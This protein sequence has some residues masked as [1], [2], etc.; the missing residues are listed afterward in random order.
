MNHSTKIPKNITILK[1]LAILKI[2]FLIQA[3]HV[4]EIAK[5]LLLSSRISK[6]LLLFV[7]VVQFHTFK[8]SIAKEKLGINNM[9]NVINNFN[10][11]FII[12]FKC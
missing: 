7:Q 3:S 10:K 8:L 5:K 9:V 12:Y 1:S 2:I 11:S 4:V 6:L